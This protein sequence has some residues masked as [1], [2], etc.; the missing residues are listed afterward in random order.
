MEVPLYHTYLYLWSH[1]GVPAEVVALPQLQ[2][3]DAGTGKQHL[4]DTLCV[5]RVPVHLKLRRDIFVMRIHNYYTCHS[6]WHIVHIHVHDIKSC[7]Y[8]AN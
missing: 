7:I 5:E 6:T 8:L 4:L 2:F 1:S 3:T